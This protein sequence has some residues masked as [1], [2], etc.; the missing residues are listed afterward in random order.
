MRSDVQVNIVPLSLASL[1]TQVD[2]NG[3]PQRITPPPPPTPEPVVFEEEKPKKT[4]FQ[5]LF[6]CCGQRSD[7]VERHGNEQSSQLT[8][9]PRRSMVQSVNLNSYTNQKAVK[10][11]N[12]AHNGYVL[13]KKNSIFS[14]HLFSPHVIFPYPTTAKYQSTTTTSSTTTESHLTVL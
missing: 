11:N 5:R 3:N 1:V 2:R 8:M 12:G 9:P 7:I 14:F 4:I 6:G 10:A 13:K